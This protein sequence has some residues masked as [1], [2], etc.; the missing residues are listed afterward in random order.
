MPPIARRSSPFRTVAHRPHGTPFAIRR[1]DYALMRPGP[2]PS[3]LAI[4]L[5]HGS[6]E[7]VFMGAQRARKGPGPHF[8]ATLASAFVL[9]CGLA[10][11]AWLVEVRG[12]GLSVELAGPRAA[13]LAVTGLGIFA[14]AAAAHFL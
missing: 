9:V 13:D 1:H 12:A 3:C 6:K 8:A 11:V 10:V 14:L 5:R 7:L 2:S 4:A